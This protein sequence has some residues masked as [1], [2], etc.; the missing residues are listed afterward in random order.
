MKYVICFYIYIYIKKKKILKYSI[1][2]IYILLKIIY[3]MYNY[4][5]LYLKNIN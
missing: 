5:E 4:I 2:N 1:Y 3:I